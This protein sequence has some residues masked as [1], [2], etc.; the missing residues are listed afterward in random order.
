[1]NIAVDQAF[2]RNTIDAKLIELRVCV[3][4]YYEPYETILFIRWFKKNTR[5][6]SW[7]SP[8]CLSERMILL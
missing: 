4:Y 3:V 8:V 7:E 6:R 2:V 5:Q 1:M